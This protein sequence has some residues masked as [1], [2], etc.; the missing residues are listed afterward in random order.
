M[1]RSLISLLIV[2]FFIVLTSCRK[3]EKATYPANTIYSPDGKIKTEVFITKQ[4]PV[5]R[6]RFH[7]VQVLNE[8][9]LGLRF[10]DAPPLTADLQITGVHV[11]QQDTVWRPVWGTDREIRNHYNQLRLD[12]KEKNA[13][14]RQITLI[15]RAF[16]DGMAFRYEL[17]RQPGLDSVFISSEET[18]F[19]FAQDD[20]A[21]WIPA[22]YESYEHLY[23]HTPVS[24][25]KA[26][27]TPVTFETP[28]GVVI[29][30]HEAALSDYPGMT[31]RKVS[32]QPPVLKSELV[33]WPDGIK[34]KGQTPLRTPWRVILLTNDAKNLLASHTIQ[35]LNEPCKIE[36][37][38]WIKPMKYVGIWW[39]MHIGVFTW[40]S[41][42]KHGATTARAKR[43][44]DF[45]AAHGF[46]GVLIEGWNEGW[47]SW[48]SG[49]NVQNYTKAYP[50]FDLKEVAAYAR[51]KG[52]ALIGHHE[53]GGNVPEYER[54]MTAA[55]DLYRKLGVPAVKT[56]YAG[57]M[58]PAGQHH[59]G[60]WM[61]RHYRKVVEE[62]AK[63]RIMIDAHEPIKP[64]GVSRTW[65]NFMSREGARGMEYNA[66]SEGNPPSHTTILPFTRF[67]GGP[68]DYTP[69]IFNLK[70]DPTG[71]H[72]VYTTLAKQLA[73]YVVLYSPLQMAAD[74]I[75]NYEN[76]PAFTFIEHVP[77]NWDETRPIAA[78]IGDYVSVARR[79]GQNWYLGTIT[80]EQPRTIVIP[81]DF[82]RPNQTY[83][84][85]IYEDSRRTDFDANPTAIN[86]RQRV[87]TSADTLH[88]KMTKSGGQAV[89]LVPIK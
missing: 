50:D 11:A 57:K 88:A 79:Q 18:R 64:T 51:R 36:D 39:G 14:H 71:K 19:N 73:Y 84:A 1:A 85:T 80:D 13:P 60:Q 41:G 21:W 43:Y 7:G 53:S 69:G 26:V 31:L 4:A 55:L 35:N 28:E 47:D 2:S 76:Q 32:S 74:L 89:E 81:L 66:W 40:H 68:M 33:P 70:F 16:N 54:Q 82:L 20:S 87:V 44:I 29:A 65:P 30:I 58:H 34:V 10:A 27:N 62:A 77:V 59:H 86:I 61:V 23:R 45:A 3:E 12:L 5:Y 72:R 63:R 48:L 17:P 42:P 9:A 83:R 25:L 15:F 56:G 37:T 78:K 67:L 52:V 6:V 22:D 24:Q 38:S 8:S 75:E 49:N 46:G